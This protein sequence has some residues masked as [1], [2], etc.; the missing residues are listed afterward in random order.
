MTLGLCGLV[1]SNKRHNTVIFDVSDVSDGHVVCVYYVSHLGDAVGCLTVSRAK[2]V[3]SE[4]TI[5]MRSWVRPCGN[6]R[7]KDRGTVCL[8]RRH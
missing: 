8:N 6:K 3:V 7:S 5:K 4:R 2:S 1:R